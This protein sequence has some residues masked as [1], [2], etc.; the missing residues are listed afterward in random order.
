ENQKFTVSN[1]P[2]S[3]FKAKAEYASLQQEAS[4][5]RYHRIRPGETLSKI[6]RREGVSIKTL[7]RLNGIKTTT[8][9]R[10]GHNLRC[11]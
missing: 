9:L 4:Q 1:Y 5:R 10:V 6:A 11:S 7:C 2:L 3:L 8:K